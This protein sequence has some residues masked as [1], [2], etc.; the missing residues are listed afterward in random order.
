MTIGNSGSS[1]WGAKWEWWLSSSSSWWECHGCT[2]P[3]NHKRRG[4]FATHPWGSTCYKMTPKWHHGSREPHRYIVKPPK[5]LF[6]CNKSS[7]P[8]R[9]SEGSFSKLASWRL[10]HNPPIANPRKKSSKAEIG[11]YFHHSKKGHKIICLFKY[12]IHPRKLTWNPK[13]GG[14]GRCFSFSKGVSSSAKCV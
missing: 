9:C 3:R 4:D 7:Q 1:S 8:S 12:H 10:H 13:T 14:L 2:V 6:D 5:Y 11:A